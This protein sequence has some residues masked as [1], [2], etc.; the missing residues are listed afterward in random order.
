M[1]NNAPVPQT[2]FASVNQSARWNSRIMAKGFCG[3]CIFIM[4][5]LLS[6]SWLTVHLTVGSL[7]HDL[8]LPDQTFDHNDDHNQYG[9]HR[10]DQHLSARPS[11]HPSVCMV[12]HKNAF[13]EFLSI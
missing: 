9:E 6:L 11:T 10:P 12:H 3:L 5:S 8:F 7:R 1:E 4:I 13:H 2:A